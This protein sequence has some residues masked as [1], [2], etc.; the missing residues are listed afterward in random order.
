[1][2]GVRR[3]NVVLSKKKEEVKET[4]RRVDSSEAC[5]RRERRWCLR[6]L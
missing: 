2:W 3:A 6:V 5:E 1:M 4:P